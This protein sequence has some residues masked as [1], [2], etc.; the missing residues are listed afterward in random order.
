MKRKKCPKCKIGR[1]ETRVKRGVLVKTFL[2][3][4]PIKRYRC[5]NCYRKSYVLGSSGIPAKHP[6]AQVL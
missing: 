5:D 6:L 3:W 2:F 1:L 4:L